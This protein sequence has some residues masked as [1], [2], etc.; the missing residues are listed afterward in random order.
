MAAVVAMTFPTSA[1][2]APVSGRIETAFAN[3]DELTITAWVTAREFVV[4][5]A[6]LRVD[7]SGPS[8]TVSSVQT[9]ERTLISGQT[10]SSA[11]I[12]VNVPKAHSALANLRLSVNGELVFETTEVFP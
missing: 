8:G 9:S 2:D 7:R 11:T 3:G 4:V 12:L 5:E 10:S 1:S 6:E